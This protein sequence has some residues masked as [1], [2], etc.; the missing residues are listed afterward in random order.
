M[1]NFKIKLIAE[2]GWNHMGDIE[3]AEKM[4]QSAALNGADICKFQS[5]N[6]KN[7]KSG[8]WDKDGRREIYKKAQ[9]SIDDHKKLIQICKSYDVEFLTSVFN[10]KDIQFLKELN[11][12]MI[13]IP[14]TE[15]YD[16]RLIEKCIS[17]FNKVLIST[18]A[19]YWN[20]LEAL[21]KNIDLSKAVFMHCVS[22]Y[23]CPIE[24]VNLPRLLLMKNFTN[25]FGYSG[26]F[27]GIDDAIAAICL[28]AIF[29][30]KHFTIDRSLAGR[31][32]KFALLPD[33]FKQIRDFAYGYR[34]M[35]EDCGLEIQ[36]CEMDYRK[37]QKGRW[38]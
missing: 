10:I 27:T 26:H 14:S 18:G 22:S 8:D 29:V 13:K 12:K 28:G 20:E 38:G 11:L 35:N 17:T 19:S 23:P 34:V 33:E 2:I 30:E 5:W 4:I 31:D 1:H 36:S 9:L 6:E 7:L 15:V 3:L 37:H 16:L 32:N 25:N 21:S 24:K